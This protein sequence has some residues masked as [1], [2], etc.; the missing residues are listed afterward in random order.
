MMRH[1]AIDLRSGHHARRHGSEKPTEML[2]WDFVQADEDKRRAGNVGESA[3]GTESAHKG[4]S[5]KSSVAEKPGVR[6][7]NDIQLERPP[8]IVRKRFWEAEVHADHAHYAH[9][10]LCNKRRFPA[11]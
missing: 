8:G 10:R 6:G 11:E 5:Q 2:R 4:C 1:P 9:Q 3:R 7:R